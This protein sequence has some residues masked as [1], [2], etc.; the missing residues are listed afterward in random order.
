[1][2]VDIRPP[3]AH[4]IL[5]LISML[6]FAGISA[7]IGIGSVARGDYMGAFFLIPPVVVVRIR[8][9]R[10]WTSGD[11]VLDRG[12]VRTVR[13]HQWEIARFTVEDVQHQVALF[14]APRRRIVFLE[15]TDGTRMRLNCTDNGFV[16][17][18]GIRRLPSDAD[19]WCAQLE[20]WR[21]GEWP[22]PRQ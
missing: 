1:M 16:R 20:A 15:R 2:D 19:Q 6:F 4:E 17:G 18:V 13:A 7:L 11:Q 22:E 12:I 5:P 9:M 21:R 3:W 8:M 14:G 10:T